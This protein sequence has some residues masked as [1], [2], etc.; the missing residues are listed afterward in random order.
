MVVTPFTVEDVVEVAG[1]LPFGE[2][3]EQAVLT[4][5]EFVVEVVSE[6]VIVTVATLL[7]CKIAS[8]LMHPD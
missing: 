2:L 8:P 3:F 4:T 1:T 7:V 6:S 5:T